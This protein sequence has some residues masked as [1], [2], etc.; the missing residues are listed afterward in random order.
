[1][2]RKLKPAALTAISAIMLTSC[3]EGAESS[4]RP[5]DMSSAAVTTAS[6]VTTTTVT[7]SATEPV[8]T[9]ESLPAE[10]SIPDS[11]AFLSQELFADVGEGVEVSI[12]DDRIIETAVVGEQGFSLVFDLS[13]WEN[14][15]SPEDM[16][17][18][19]RLFWQSYPR[20]YARFGEITEAPYDVIIAISNHG[21]K[22]ARTSGNIIR[23]HDQWLADNP[24]DYDCITREL[25]N[26]VR[27]SSSWDEEFLEYGSYPDLF[28]DLCRY[29]YPLDGGAFNDEVWALPT[30]DVQNTRETSVRFLVWLDCI[31]SD[32]ANGIDLIARFCD[33]CSSGSYSFDQWE[34]AW[35]D[36]FLDTPLEG[37][38]A[39]EVWKLYTES[40]FAKLDSQ[41]EKGKTSELLAKYDIRGK[42]E[43]PDKE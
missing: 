30:A 4:S 18:L 20:M 13:R 37:K 7:T 9:A 5:E 3:S 21:S 8:T 40:D 17:Q 27:N 15:T 29:E 14:H 43:L 33:I 25:G 1:M 42:L 24:G 41:A 19:S 35:Q 31:Y 16:V 26:I 32:Y 34:A 22:A 6:S 12:D 28:A 10:E 11:R 23:L 39:D 2:K 36:I 38:T